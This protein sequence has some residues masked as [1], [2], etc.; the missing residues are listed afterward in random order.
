MTQYKCIYCNKCYVRKSAYNNHTLTCKFNRTIRNLN[1]DDSEILFPNHEDKSDSYNN[2]DFIKPQYSNENIYKLLINLYNKY[3][4]LE[5]DYDELKK[6]VVQTKNKI[7]VIE[8]LNNNYDCASF[9]YRD[10]INTIKIDIDDLEIIFKKDFA[11]GIK[12]I[13]I[14]NLNKHDTNILPIKAFCHKDGSL[15]IYYEESKWI[16]ISYQE[17]VH[18]IKFLEK[19]ILPLFLDWK[20]ANEKIINEEQF[21][22]IYVINMKKVIASNFDKHNVYN[23][24]KNK[25][26]KEI[27]LDLKKIINY[28]FV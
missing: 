16:I 5:S 24:I 26:Y 20:I 4:K 13:F 12:E 28:E 7:D 17:F 1:I 3:E 22:Q 25:I 14:K 15:Y 27:K 10:F 11:E 18:T 2:V 8:Y 6:Y 23:L 21:S 19:Q 9:T